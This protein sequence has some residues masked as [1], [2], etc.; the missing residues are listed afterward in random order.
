MQNSEVKTNYSI[1]ISQI[2]YR[3]CDKKM[4]FIRNEIYRKDSNSNLGGFLIKTS[5]D[6]TVVYKKKITYWGNKW[7]INFWSIDFSKFNTEGLFYLE[8]PKI[9]LK[10]ENFEIKK[11]IF[12]KKTLLETSIQQLE[13]KLGNK[14]GWQDCGSDLRAV[15]G[16]AIQLIGLIDCFISFKKILNESQSDDFKKHIEIGCEYLISCQREN[17]SFMNELYVAEDK[18]NWTLSILAVIALIKAFAITNKID[19]LL[20][21]RKGWEWCIKKCKYA[22]NEVIEEIEETRKIFGKYEPWLPPRELRAR[23][24]LL[25]IW[26]GTELYSNTNDLEFKNIAIDYANEI[27][28]KLQFLDLSESCNNVYGNFY[29]WK[30]SDL[31]QKSWEHVG[32][33]YCCGS[34][35]PDE[36]SGFINLV[37]MFRNDKSWFKWWYLL[38]QY[39]YGYLKQTS[40]LTP[41]GIYPLG[42]FD[43]EIR[44]FGPSWHGFN[45]IYGRIANLSMKLARLF[46]DYDLELIALNNLQWIAGLNIGIR[47]KKG[48][49]KGLSWIYGIGDNY[50]EAWT[51]IKGSISNGFCANPQFKLEHIDNQIDLPNYITTEDWIVHTGSWLSGLSEFEKNSKL[52]I[53]TNYR[54]KPINAKIGF[55][56]VKNFKIKKTNITN[57]YEIYPLNYSRNL[58]I[59]ANWNNKIIEKDVLI[60]SGDIKRIVLDFSDY[61][62]GNIE[63][64]FNESECHVEVINKGID[65]TDI[66]IILKTIGIKI[67]GSNKIKGNLKFG[68]KKVYKFHAEFE[69]DYINK[70]VLI[71]A[72]VCSNYSKCILET[73]HNNYK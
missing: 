24:K 61:I 56:K 71:R 25:I 12:R 69:K 42:T 29:A 36:I 33:G 31:H 13:K 20:S 51:K 55:N 26:A 17:G 62:Q 39:A 22:D 57:N 8:V 43:G 60:I 50:V 67:R 63:F 15:E 3:P 34:V 19:H 65:N 2:G 46:K 68:E 30:N 72:E 53:R 45:G 4:A 70:P 73:G 11:N 6:D 23:D 35:L 32:W 44:F 52:I 66:K 54:G 21:S 58:G 10:S 37:K 18:K 47:K 38:K 41:F 64:K 27:A 14:K 49:F 28:L 9:K 7:N 40:K 5:H 59:I 48:K 16:T 1:L